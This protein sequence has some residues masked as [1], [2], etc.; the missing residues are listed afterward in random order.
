[1]WRRAGFASNQLARRGDWHRYGVHPQF[2]GGGGHVQTPLLHLGIDHR[3]SDSP[4]SCVEDEGDGWIRDVCVAPPAGTS[5]A[6]PGLY[7]SRPVGFTGPPRVMPVVRILDRCA[8]YAPNRRRPGKMLPFDFSS[9]AA[10]VFFSETFDLRGPTPNVVHRY[11]GRLADYSF[12]AGRPFC[13]GF[14]SLLTD[15]MPR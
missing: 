3:L 8:A 13:D 6:E 9:P 2:A 1:M 15:T 7:L 14:V 12:G 11:E 4:T 10:A 5:K